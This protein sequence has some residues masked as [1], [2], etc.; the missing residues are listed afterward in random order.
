MSWFVHLPDQG[1]P[2]A[3]G[4]VSMGSLARPGGF[5]WAQMDVQAGAKAACHQAFP[6]E[7]GAS[8]GLPPGTVCVIISPLACVAEEG[9]CM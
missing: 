9:V 3:Q 1:A 6:R 5:P 2:Q 4:S 8:R 7:R